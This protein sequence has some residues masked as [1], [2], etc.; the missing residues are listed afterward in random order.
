ML[1]NLNSM[2][3]AV[4]YSNRYTNYLTA[5]KLPFVL[6]A[7]YFRDILNIGTKASVLTNI[8]SYLFQFQQIMIDE[9]VLKLIFDSSMNTPAILQAYSQNSSK[10]S[11]LSEL[12]LIFLI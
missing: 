12:D 10:I 9:T 4:D 7:W 1:I 6:G 8:Q 5:Y 3:Y 11:E 2:T